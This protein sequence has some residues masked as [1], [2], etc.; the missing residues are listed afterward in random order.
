MAIRFRRPLTLRCAAALLAVAVA[1]PADLFAA[2]AS[3]PNTESVNWEIMSQIRNEGF[4]NSKVMEIEGQLTDVIGPRLTGSPN[5]KRANEW[6]RDQF[7]EW[8]LVNSHL[9]SFPFG[10]GWSNSYTEVRMVAPQETPALAYPKAWTVSTNG[11]LRAPVVKAKLATKEDLDKYRGQLGGK[12]VLDGDMREIKPQSEAA[13]VRYDD[14][15][16]SEI[17]QYEIPSEKPRFNREEIAQRIAF[18]KRHAFIQNRD[19]T[20]RLDVVG[21]GVGEPHPIIRNAGANPGA[22]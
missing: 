19:I 12:I 7:R 9:E 10:R 2:T 5:M 17:A 8:G 13:L 20:R 1:A 11:M 15:K 3:L 22:G 6:T 4:H 21:R 18:Q 14:K 16:L